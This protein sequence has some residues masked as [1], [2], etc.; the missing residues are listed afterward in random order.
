MVGGLIRAARGY[1]LGQVNNQLTIAAHI[2]GVLSLR[3]EPVTSDE[4]AAGFGTSPVV[5]RR[6]LSQLKR[7]G[8][9][10]SRRGAGGGSVLAQPAADITL[11][12]AY[13]AVTDRDVTLLRR[14]PGGGCEAAPQIVPILADY[15]NELYGEAERALL[16]RLGAVTVADLVEVVGDRARQRGILPSCS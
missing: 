13:A 1:I 6:V 11:R 15:I 7:A 5:V 12:D 8:L 9:I 14:H 2:L 16:E 3:S 4:L 10:D